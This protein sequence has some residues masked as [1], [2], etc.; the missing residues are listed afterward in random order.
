MADQFQRAR[1]SAHDIKGPLI[2]IVISPQDRD[3]LVEVLRVMA[4]AVITD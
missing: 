2:A 1:I 4:E 3:I